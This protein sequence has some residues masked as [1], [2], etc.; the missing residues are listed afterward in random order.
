[1][2]HSSL[3]MGAHPKQPAGI[4]QFLLL[5]GDMLVTSVII[6]MN[7]TSM[8]C[9]PR[10]FCWSQ[11]R[12]GFIPPGLGLTLLFPNCSYLRAPHLELHDP[13][14][15]AHP[16]VCFCDQQSP[17][18][19][20]APLLRVGP[21]SSFQQDGWPWNMSLWGYSIIHWWTAACD[22]WSWNI[23]PPLV[24][25]SHS[26]IAWDAICAMNILKP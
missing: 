20:K 25:L 21:V 13:F 26:M 1:M 6:L 2:L 4:S 16:S 7:G 18:W 22:F 23:F 17:V 3:L 9:W 5:W 12:T 11:W 10:H 14:A 8:S 15:N 19:L 24:Q